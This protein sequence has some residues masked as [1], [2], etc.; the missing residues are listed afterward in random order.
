MNEKPNI[1]FIILDSARADFF[2]C[3]GYD[4]KTTP[5]IDKIAKEGV[6][7]K[8]AYAPSSWTGPS[9]T[10]LFTGKYWSRIKIPYV[11]LGLSNQEKG[12]IEENFFKNNFVK[13]LNNTGYETISYTINNILMK[14]KILN[15]FKKQEIDLA[16]KCNLYIGQNVLEKPLKIPLLKSILTLRFKKAFFYA[17][18]IFKKL[19]IMAS[20]KKA[21]HKFLFG[22]RI[23]I[24]RYVKKL[25]SFKKPFFLFINSM[26][27]HYEYQSKKRNFKNL[28]YEDYEEIY[29]DSR[30][31]IGPLMYLVDENIPVSE[32]QVEN[33]KK[34]YT[35][36]LNYVDE[37][38]GKMYRELQK[39]GLLENTIFII[40]SDHGDEFYEKGIFGHAKTL[41][42]GIIRIP[43]IIKFPDKFNIKG[44]YDDLASLID[45]F[46][47][48]FGLL[49]IKHHETDGINLFK[50][51]NKII[52]AEHIM[53]FRSKKDEL[54]ICAI[55]KDY[56]YMKM[57]DGSKRLF[58]NADFY[59]KNNI[60]NKNK[61]IVDSFENEIKKIGLNEK[62]LGKTDFVMFD[63][64]SLKK[65]MEGLG[66][67]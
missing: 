35:A 61:N 23:G 52:F 54:G 2:S 57:S 4:K 29:F 16:N 19:I 33:T 20:K 39:K 41:N 65:E 32:K 44:P 26:G 9:H 3:Y 30:N 49:G 11:N 18:A 34:L 21:N 51:K 50:Q 63:K 62:C 66:Y 1:V 45:V 7:F 25:S 24:K 42:N 36:S 27:T 60:I 56:K 47:S 67:L 5:N 8:N 15:I 64:S 14:G 48:I 6:L 17:N 31:K 38:V 22:D 58:K 53:R 59:E 12:K 28:G 10:A 13:I 40:A 43:L 46:P 37:F 55:N